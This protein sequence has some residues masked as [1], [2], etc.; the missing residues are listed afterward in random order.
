MSGITL[1]PKYGVNP[2]LSQCFWCGKDKNEIALLGIQSKRLTGKEKA[3]NR[4]VLD[5]KPCAKCIEGMALG[6]TVIE[7]SEHEKKGYHQVGPGLYYSGRW[8]VLKE[9]AFKRI[10]NDES[11]IKAALECRKSFITEEAYNKLGLPKE[12]YDSRMDKKDE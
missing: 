8:F 2:T 11:L 9:E 5:F 12:N 4:V 10:F 3:P 7:A 6:I 1:H